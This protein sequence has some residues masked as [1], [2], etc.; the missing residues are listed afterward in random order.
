MNILFASPDRDLVR[1]YQTLLE[2]EGHR[3]S[4]AYDGIQVVEALAALHPKE[5]FGCA[6]LDKSLP[7]VSLETLME[8]IQTFSIPLILLS[9]EKE[10]PGPLGKTCFH[11]TYPFE[12]SELFEAINTAPPSGRE[13]EDS[14]HE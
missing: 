14:C 4:P 7:R 10:G 12:P 8:E 13:S 2:S 5:A 6:V 11:L 9:K 3:V 1:A